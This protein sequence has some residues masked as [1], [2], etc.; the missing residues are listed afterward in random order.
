[1][2]G[3]EL[4]VHNT[5]VAEAGSIELMTLKLNYIYIE[6]DRIQTNRWSITNDERQEDSMVAITST[7]EIT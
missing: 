6:F 2:Y 3:N 5:R 7:R 1:M 4:N